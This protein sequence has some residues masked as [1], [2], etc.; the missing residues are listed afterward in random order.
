MERQGTDGGRHIQRL[1]LTGTEE[2]MRER[3]RQRE[4]MKKKQIKQKLHF[5]P[6]EVITLPQI[7]CRVEEQQHS[8][9]CFSLALHQ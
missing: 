9:E 5:L 4:S 2:R 6:E 7:A 3:N 8:F 1:Q